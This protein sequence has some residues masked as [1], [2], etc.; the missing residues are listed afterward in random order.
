MT[1]GHA[2]IRQNTGLVANTALLDFDTYQTVR[3]HPVL[4][5]M[6]KYT[7]GGLV[8]DAELREVFK[9]QKLL[10]ANCIRNAALENAT[11]SMVNIWG[12]NFLLCHV[13]PSTGMRTAT[14][15]LQFRWL[16]PELPA[17]WAVR[18]YDDPDP[19]K[20]CEITEA[21]YYSTEKVIA[22]ELAYLVNATL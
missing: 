12:N 18:V 21:G 9:V 8:N 19:G 22:R 1:T 14:F 17:P 7:Q 13:A 11:A 4:L 16:N 3:R 15:G 20:K 6:Y 2:F 10:V 5:D